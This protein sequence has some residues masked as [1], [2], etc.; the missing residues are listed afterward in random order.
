AILHLPAQS[1]RYPVLALKWIPLDHVLLPRASRGARIF[2]DIDPHAELFECLDPIFGDQCLQADG[3]IFTLSGA[4][5]N[6]E[7]MLAQQRVQ[8]AAVLRADENTQNAFLLGHIAPRTRGSIL[9]DYGE[10]CQ[11]LDVSK[12]SPPRFGICRSPRVSWPNRLA[13]RIAAERSVRTRWYF[14]GSEHRRQRRRY[15]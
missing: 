9:S 7:P 10:L 8:R 15:P 14:T 5:H 13:V 6:V 12:E 1:A 2:E 11:L 3:A 4:A